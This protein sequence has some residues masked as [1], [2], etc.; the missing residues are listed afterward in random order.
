MRMRSATMISKRRGHVCLPIEKKLHFVVEENHAD[1]TIS[2]AT[3]TATVEISSVLHHATENLR[4]RQRDNG[5]L[6]Y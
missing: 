1:T 3:E 4:S 2:D 5:I 6:T